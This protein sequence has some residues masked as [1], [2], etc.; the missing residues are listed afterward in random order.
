MVGYAVGKRPVLEHGADLPVLH[1]GRQHPLHEFGDRVDLPF[2]VEFDLVRLQQGVAARASSDGRAEVPDLS[3]LNDLLA[4]LDLDQQ[5]AVAHL[6]DDEPVVRVV[7]HGVEAAVLELGVVT[8]PQLVANGVDDE[9]HLY[10]LVVSC[11]CVIKTIT[12]L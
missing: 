1:A 4:L 8:A 11:A 12:Y 5:Q 7:R 3:A 9:S 10:S 2:R 6:S